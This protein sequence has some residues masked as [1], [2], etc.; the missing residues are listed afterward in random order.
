M[1]DPP[2]VLA[3]LRVAIPAPECELDFRSPW[4]L[5]VATILSAQSTDRMVNTVTPELFRR[6]PGPA[7]LARA[8]RA[9]VEQVVHRTG[10]F[11]NKAKSIQGAAEA[12]MRDHGGEVPRELD[13]LVALPGVAR[14][15]ANVV[16]GTAFGIPSGMVVDTHIGRVARVLGFSVQEDPAKVEQDLCGLFPREEWID[17]GHRLLLHGRYVCL[18]RAPR[19]GECPLWELCPSRQSE[20]AQGEWPERAVSA[21]RRVASRGVEG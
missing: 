4:E 8:E 5:L 19:C 20:T 1:A 17:T 6:W 18:A 14:K 2:E 13:A 3:R 21:A 9:E 7:A 11:R 15:T 10:F 12:V 16:L